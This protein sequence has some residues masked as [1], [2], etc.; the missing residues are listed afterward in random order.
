ML[1]LQ[2]HVGLSAV[3]IGSLRTGSLKA[4][5]WETLR[6]VVQA[7]TPTRSGAY[8]GGIAHARSPASKVDQ[9]ML[10]IMPRGVERC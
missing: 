3:N 6:T 8:A 2:N 7:M 5:A 9:G 1:T 10:R 4:H